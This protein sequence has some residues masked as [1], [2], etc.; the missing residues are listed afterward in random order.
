MSNETKEKMSESHK[1]EKNHFFGKSHSNETLLIKKTI[2]QLD[3]DNNFIKEWS[4]V[5]EASRELGISQSGIS[6][7]LSGKYNITSGFKFIYKN[8]K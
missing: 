8:G 1:S 2:I 4:G 5:N 3:K 7:A 6:L